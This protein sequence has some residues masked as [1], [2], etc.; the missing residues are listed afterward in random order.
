MNMFSRCVRS[1]GLKSMTYGERI[2]AVFDTVGRHI[3]GG[4][5][6]M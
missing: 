2:V 3:D 6:D 5:G 4:V 1:V